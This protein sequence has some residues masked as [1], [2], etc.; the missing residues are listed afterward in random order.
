MLK[1][2]FRKRD[3]IIMMIHNQHRITGFYLFTYA[4]A[5]AAATEKYLFIRFY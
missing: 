4:V 5:A 1:Y 3:L 2:V